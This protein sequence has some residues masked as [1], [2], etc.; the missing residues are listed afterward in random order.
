MLNNKKS[1]AWYLGGMANDMEPGAGGVFYVNGIDGT[2]SNANDGQTP[3]TPLLTLTYALSLCTA[4]ADN[5]IVILDYWQPTGETWPI[6]VNVDKVHV[7]GVPGAGAQW[8]T[9]TPPGDTAALSVS[10]GYVEIARLTI[11]GGATHGCV[12]TA[13]T[14]WGLWLRDCWLGVTGTGQDGFRGVAPFD[15]PYLRITRCRFGQGLTRDGVRLDHNAT[16]GSIG[17]P[18]E[19]NLF[20]RIPGVAIN[21]VG[22]CSEVGIYDNIVAVPANTAGGA[23][24]FSAG[25]ANCIVDGNR[26]NFGD[27]AMGNNP[28]TDGAGAGANNWILNYQA[29]T[30]VLPA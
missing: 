12:E 22:N 8:P 13:A 25:C 23:I 18:G 21:L 27:T 6:D 17:R 9:L 29:A 20:D 15:L 1:P 2:G 24:T 30:A 4:N 10:A 14:K 7:V 28:Y 16:R 19:G 26:A 5:Y 3:S 11:D